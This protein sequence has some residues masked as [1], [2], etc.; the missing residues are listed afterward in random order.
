[1]SQTTEYLPLEKALK[2]QVLDA[3]N[4]RTKPVLRLLKTG[5][6]ST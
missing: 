4:S 2:V 5:I 6:T 1:M 3:L